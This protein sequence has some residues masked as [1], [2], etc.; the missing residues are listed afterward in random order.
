M[1]E[2]QAHQ[3]K[4]I[5]T[6]LALSDLQQ[7]QNSPH[8]ADWIVTLAFYKALHAV[9]SYFAK[10]EIHPRGHLERNRRVQE[11]LEEIFPRYDALYSASRIARYEADTYQDTPEDVMMLVNSSLD[12]ESYINTLLEGH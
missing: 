7:S 4:Q 12:I 1:P 8:H 9:D 3:D 2:I 10:L 5:G 11:L 6:H